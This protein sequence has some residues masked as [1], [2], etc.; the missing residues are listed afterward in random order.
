MLHSRFRLAIAAPVL[1]FVLLTVLLTVLFPYLIYVDA[2]RIPI[3]IYCS[4]GVFAFIWAWI[5]FGMLRQHTVSVELNETTI[6][7]RSF[8]G[9]GKKRTYPLA[10]FDGYSIVAVPPWNRHREAV[11]LHRAGKP[12]LRLHGHYLLNYEEIKAF[13]TARVPFSGE[14]QFRQL[15]EIKD[16]FKRF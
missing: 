6:I 8:I 12:D 13:V 9:W 14:Q 1:L 5:T 11:Y 2:S 15:D 16:A 10:A 4:I 7:L 3:L